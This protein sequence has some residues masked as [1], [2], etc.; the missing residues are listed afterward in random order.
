[1]AK[2]LALVSKPTFSPNLFVGGIDAENW[3]ALSRSSETNRCSN[4]AHCAAY[5]GSTYKPFHGAGGTTG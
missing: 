3:A 4:R 5:P 1:M 2:S